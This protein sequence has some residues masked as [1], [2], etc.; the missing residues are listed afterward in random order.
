MGLNL[1]NSTRLS[2][3]SLGKGNKGVHESG[4][5]KFGQ[6]LVVNDPK[7]NTMD[8]PWYLHYTDRRDS[9][10]GGFDTKKKCIQWYENKGR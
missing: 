7:Y 6:V 2:K 3:Q 5:Y 4:R 9:V 10:T 8:K 1:K